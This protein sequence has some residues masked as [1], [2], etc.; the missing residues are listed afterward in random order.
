VWL[1]SMFASRRAS[2]SLAAAVLRQDSSRIAVVAPLQG[3]RWTYGDLSNRAGRL[4]G[5]LAAR[6]FRQ[7]DVIATDL[8]SVPENLVLQL[9]A[10]HLGAATLSLKSAKDLPSFR[11]QLAVRCSVVSDAESFLASE[12]FEL[13]GYSVGSVDGFDS[14][15]EAT[16]SSGIDVPTVVPD[17]GALGYY[18]SSKAVTN[19]QALE[20]GSA[21]AEKL[22]MEMGDV[23]LVS[24]TFNHL[25]GIGSALSG[26][27]QSGAAVVV[28]DASGVVGCG[29][30]AQ[31]AQVTAQCLEE[32]GCTILFAD[33]HTLKAL[34]PKDSLPAFRGGVCKVGSGTTFLE[35]TVE[36]AGVK[37]FTIGKK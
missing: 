11:E 20:V 6:G 16:E 22:S 19:S 32:Q 8:P 28:P 3:I 1:S 13:G 33:T 12:K 23:V 15:Q 29:V 2:A 37:L 25:F 31:R 35:D 18:N 21:A 34:P 14:F 7:G 10:S 36:Y 9:A 17:P 27:L 4:A 30:P 5:A 24:I 26:A